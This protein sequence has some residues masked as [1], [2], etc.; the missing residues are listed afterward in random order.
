MEVAYAI[1]NAV[2]T[3]ISGNID[4]LRN[5]VKLQEIEIWGN[6]NT[7]NGSIETFVSNHSGKRLWQITIVWM[8]SDYA[9]RGMIDNGIYGDISVFANYYD[10]GKLQISGYS[11]ITGELKS[12]KNLKKIYYVFLR[13]CSCTG[14]K[15]D[16]YNNGANISTFSV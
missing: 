15:A 14:S 7:V 3:S 9:Y 13:R 2:G 10:M 16:L 8:D 1:H 4:L 5:L 11:T 6:K 12:L